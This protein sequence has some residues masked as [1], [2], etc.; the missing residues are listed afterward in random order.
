MVVRHIPQTMRVTIEKLVHGGLGLSRSAEGVI[1]VE[2]VLPGEV[3]EIEIV[4]RQGGVAVARCVALLE[5]SPHRTQPGCAYASICGGCDWQHI[6]YREQVRQ[7]QAIV[8]ECLQR[9]GRLK[10]V[11]SIEIFPSAPWKYRLRAQFKVDRHH[12]A[13]GFFRQNSHDVVAIKRCPLLVDGLDA[14]LTR[15]SEVLALLPQD[16]VEI[17]AVCGDN[18]AVATSPGIT[19]F[20]Q[21]STSI[22]VGS[23]V[24][25]VAGDAFFQ[26][27]R[28][29]LQ[30][31]GEWAR[32]YAGGDCCID[33]FGGAGFFS[34]M[35]SDRFKSGILVESMPQLVCQAQANFSA[36]RVAAFTAITQSAE[37]FFIDKR[38]RIRPDC[39]IVD[40]PRQGLTPAVRNGIAQLKPATLLSV[41]CDPATQA[42]DI[43]FFIDKCGYRIERAA[44]FDLY[45]QTHHIETMVLLKSS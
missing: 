4:R 37:S 9:I 25:T 22:T 18:G 6:D 21:A 27:N 42:R 10:T 3:A 28:H 39:L 36:N 14:L 24:F 23:A 17:K 2:S 34:L 31:F 44:L 35:L 41:S 40:P 29:L 13:I 20:S 5:Q 33:M 15:Q 11:P 43:G 38:N 26:G 7:K 45:P 30:A 32:P 8:I 16:T 19:G 12:Q 1:L